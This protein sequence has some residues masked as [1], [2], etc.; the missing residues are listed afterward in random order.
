MYHSKKCIVI[1]SYFKGVGLTYMVD[2]EHEVT[3]L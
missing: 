3:F 1:P 2:D